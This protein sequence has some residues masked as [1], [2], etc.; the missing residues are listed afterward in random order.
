MWMKTLE[1][2]RIYTK[3]ALKNVTETPLTNTARKEQE[4]TQPRIHAK[5]LSQP[6]HESGRTRG[7]MHIHF[8]TYAPRHIH[9]YM[10]KGTPMLCTSPTVRIQPVFMKTQQSMNTT[11][12]EQSNHE[13]NN[14]CRM[15]TIPCK[16]G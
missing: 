15:R 8:S 4:H 5:S 6:P 16:N 9:G 1:I 12:H 14:S 2:E 10:D 13:Q 7:H 3:L 11:I